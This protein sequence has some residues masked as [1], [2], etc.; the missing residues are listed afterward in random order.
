MFGR[1]SVRLTA[2]VYARAEDAARN[3]GY[4]SVDEFVAHAVG[5][6]LDRLN[7]GVAGAD[8]EEVEKQLRG[9]G[10]IE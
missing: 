4:S 10:Y 5:K 3:E 2:E 1:P 7:A 8:K 6:E 9:L